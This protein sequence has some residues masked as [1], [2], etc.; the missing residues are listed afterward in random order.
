[1]SH[2]EQICEEYLMR[3]IEIIEKLKF[4]LKNLRFFH[5][6][7]DTLSIS[8]RGFKFFKKNFGNIEYEPTKVVLTIISLKKG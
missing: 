5:L 7:P 3:V 1:M 4:S 6:E 8:Q 2:S